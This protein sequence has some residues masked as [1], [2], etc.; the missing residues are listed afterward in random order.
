MSKGGDKDQQRAE[1]RDAKRD[2]KSAS[3]AGVSTGASK[4]IG[5]GEDKADALHRE[6]GKS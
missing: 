2:G 6:K 3:E 4:Q 5:A 1:V